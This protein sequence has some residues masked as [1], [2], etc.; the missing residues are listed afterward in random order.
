MEEEVACRGG[1][2]AWLAAKVQ[3]FYEKLGWMLWRGKTRRII[4]D[5]L[6]CPQFR[7]GCEPRVMRKIFL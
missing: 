5:C 4:S 2:E 7:N 6:H 3:R 1:E